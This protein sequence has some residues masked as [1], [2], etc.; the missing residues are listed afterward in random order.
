MP[1]E[2]EVWKPVDGWPYEVSSIG[3]VRRLL[4]GQSG[5]R[6]GRILKPWLAGLCG[7]YPSVRLANRKKQKCFLVHRLVAA[8]FGGPIPPGMQV[9]H[10]NGIKGDARPENLEVVTS[11]QNMAHASR[12]GLIARGERNRHAKLNE[13]Q[14]RVIRRLDESADISQRE[15]AIVFGVIQQ[16]VSAIHKMD[17][18][19]YLGRA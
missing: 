2:H 13:L 6:T 9:N 17:N 14:V 15:I 8:S 16:T 4:R 11:Q 18:W 7:G 3:R 5:R 1:T 10:K 12:S 19:S